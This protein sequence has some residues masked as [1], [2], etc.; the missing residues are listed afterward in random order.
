MAK[1]ISLT[2]KENDRELEIYNWLQA[3]VN[4]GAV[5][6]E[7]LLI[8]MHNEKHGIIQ[9]VPK[10]EKQLQADTKR[11]DDDMPDINTDLDL[12]DMPEF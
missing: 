2:F 1:Q 12:D 3:K 4:K 8:A 9:A 5:I 6:K 10:Y 11:I 7:Q